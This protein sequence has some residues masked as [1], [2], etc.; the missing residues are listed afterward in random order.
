MRLVA[1]SR[2]F[3]QAEYNAS[4]V[5]MQ[6]FGYLR[7]DV[8]AAGYDL[9]LNVFLDNRQPNN[10]RRMV[11]AFLT[12]AEYQLRFSSFVTNTNAECRRNDDG[13]QK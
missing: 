6:Y 4:F 5:Q 10:H 7:R 3:A 8:D 12:S 11:C 9:R 13:L 2:A 1:D